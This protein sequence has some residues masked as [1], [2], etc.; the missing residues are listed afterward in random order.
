MHIGW[1]YLLIA[2]FFEICFS[3]SLKLSSGFSKF[4][5]SIITVLFICLSFFSFSQ[6]MKS[7]SLGTAYAVWAGIGAVG[8]VSCGIIFFGESCD[9]IRIL[10]IIVIVIGIVGLKF[11]TT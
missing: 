7:I 2:G 3:V 9:V 11:S 8:S 4:I 5:P 10:A 1:I 6:A